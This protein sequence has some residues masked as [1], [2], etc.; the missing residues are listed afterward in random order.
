MLVY[1][2]ARRRTDPREALLGIGERARLAPA[3]PAGLATHEALVEIFIDAAELAQGLADEAFEAAGG[4]DEFSP[5]TV[6]ATELLLKLA[7]ALAR[8]WCSGLQQQDVDI[9]AAAQALAA[10]PLPDRI[11]CKRAEGYAFYALYPE[12]LI[13]ASRRLPSHGDT[14]VIGIRS[15]GFGLAA[16]VAAATGLPPPLTVRPVGHP[17]ARRLSLG[18][19]IGAT[20][21][22]PAARFA[23][24]DEGPGLS[25]SSFAAVFDALAERGVRDEQID[26][27]PGHA[28]EPG[29]EAAPSALQRWRGLAR[30][31]VGFDQLILH[32]RD[33]RLRLETWAADLL[34][35]LSAPLEDLSGG[36][37]RGLRYADAAAWPASNVSQERLKYRARTL[38]GEWLLKFNGLGRYGAEKHARGRIVA[39]AGFTPPLAG[40]RHGFL[41]E[42]WLGDARALDPAAVSREALVA[43]VGDY[44]GFRA[45]HLPAEPEAGASPAELAAMLRRNAELGEA[46]PVAD[47]DRFCAALSRSAASPCPAVTDNRLHAHEWLETAEGRIIKTDALDHAAAH[48]LVGCQDIAWDIAGAATE[49]GFGE[50][51]LDELVVRVERAAERN[52]DRRLL[53]LLRPCY[54][55]FQL[56]SATLA[57]DSLADL[58]EEAMRLGREADRYRRDLAATFRRLL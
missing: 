54:L 19:K 41:V 40:L 6:A 1:G 39:E 49:L 8:S 43:R 51:E 38:A 13:E 35:P 55:A 44:L 27:L 7:Q 16:L 28:G 20:F 15:I 5:V 34:G 56:G 11:S 50:A 48:D 36:R 17:F 31:V 42:R 12:A 58:P 37:W 24:V 32:N 46:V 18:P 4:V 33:P 21:G 14:R 26:V 45:K 23:V 3:L 52:V 10:L 29:P 47:L 57:R 53:E 9:D 25:G 30:H 2:D 22:G